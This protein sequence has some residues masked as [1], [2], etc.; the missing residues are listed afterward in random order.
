MSRTAWLAPL[1]A[2][3]LA[4]G[5]CGEP[6]CGPPDAPDRPA[7]APPDADPD[8]PGGPLAPPEAPVAPR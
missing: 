4:A 7:P 3:A 1:L 5:A 2:L 8:P 6:R